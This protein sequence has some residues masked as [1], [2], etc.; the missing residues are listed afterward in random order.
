[1][2]DEIKDNA[3][4]S[5]PFLLDTNSLQKPMNVVVLPGMNSEQINN[6]YFLR[7]KTKANISNVL[8][9]PPNYNNETNILEE[10]SPNLDNIKGLPADDRLSLIS[11]LQIIKDDQY[12]IEE[13][14]IS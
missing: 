12:V 6:Q 5:Q 11:K 7:N 2:K 4:L 14:L 13:G 1:M 8:D 9:L 3:L 10:I